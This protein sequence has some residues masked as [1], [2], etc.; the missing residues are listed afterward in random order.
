LLRGRDSVPVPLGP[1]APDLEGAR[2]FLTAHLGAVGAVELVGEGMWSRA[3]GFVHD[4]RE[5]VARFGRHVD[6]YEKDRRAASWSSPELPVP[7]VLEIAP[8]D[9]GWCCITERVHGDVLEQLDADGWRA[10]LPALVDVYDAL[11]AIDVSATQG[12]GGWDGDGVARLASWADFLLAV[13]VDDATRRTHGWRDKLVA[14]RFGDAAFVDGE[15]ALRRL[16]GELP[17]IDRTVVHADLINRNVFVDAA[18][19]DRVTAVFDWGCSLYGDMLYELAWMQMWEPWYPAMRDAGVVA[20]IT[21]HV[22]AREPAT[23]AFDERLTACLLHIGL[24]HI[25]YNA[26]TGDTDTL[27]LVIERT[28][29]FF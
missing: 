20:A 7:R 5:L 24:D 13:G 16:V 23:P 1:F 17:E 26:W 8:W 15:R 19:A 12:W 11:R 18:S 9:A 27:G 14:S 10:V 2:R 3:F 6:D 29:S 4:G 21:R 28:R 22:R 25:A